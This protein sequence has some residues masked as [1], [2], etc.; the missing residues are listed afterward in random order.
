M[1]KVQTVVIGDKGKFNRIGKKILSYKGNIGPKA[2]KPQYQL[3]RMNWEF[4]AY[5]NDF[6]PSVP[7]GHSGRYKLNV[8]TGAIIDSTTGLIVGFLRKK[9][10]K[11]LLNDESF[12]RLAISA[13]EY[14]SKINSGKILPHITEAQSIR[15]VK[16]RVIDRDN[17][18][19]Y[20]I[21]PLIVSPHKKGH[22]KNLTYTFKTIAIFNKK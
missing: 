7:H 1:R 10:M 5:D 19:H 8:D 18:I 16:R 22:D 9:E 6:S 11:R 2:Y 21:K 17:R 12:K 14:Y 15:S 20:R 4:H 13:R 3:K